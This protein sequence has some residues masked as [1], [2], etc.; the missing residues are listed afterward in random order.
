MKANRTKDCLFLVLL[1]TMMCF[2]A[3]S[4]LA[5][6]AASE[7]NSAAR[8]YLALIENF[9]A[10]AEHHWN[11]KE[12][13][14]DAAGSG[15]TWA[16]G[17]GGVCLVMAVLLTEYPE[18]PEFFP[19]KV[20]RK[21]LIDQVRRAI[22]SVCFAGGS[23]TDPRAVKPSK[24]G[25]ID[26]KNGG[27]HWQG[28]LETEHW[29]L[30]AHLLDAELDNDTRELVRQ[31]ATAEADAAIRSIPSAK[32][33]NTAAD[34][35]AWNAGLLGV[36]SAIYGNDPRAAKWD[37]WAKRWALNMEA[38]ET[39]RASR[40]IIDGRPLGEWLVSTNVFPDLTLE[41]HGF[42]DLPYQPGFAAMAEPIIAYQLCGRKIPEAFHANAVE[43][44]N[45]ILKWLVL[46]DGDLLC[47]QGI[48]WAERDVQHSWAFSILG[49]LEDQAWARAAE[50]RCLKL[51][52]LRQANFGDGSIHAL[53]FGYETDLAVVW[54]F[55]F[56]LHKHFGKAESGLAFDE[57]RGSKIF[58]Y[59]AAAVHRT[60]DLVSSV[61]WFRTRQAIMISP[62][63]L[64]SLAERP[65]FT[66]YDPSSGTGWI[67]FKGEKNG[68]RSR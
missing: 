16:R 27:N 34:D 3:E 44:G 54:T 45:E 39:D 17:N 28:G 46:P 5:Q 2:V 32:R 20:P 38:R 40:R 8:Q 62:N 53:D 13:S 25:G 31:V 48:D 55:S 14:Y 59:V 23:C 6:P 58:P 15:V 52:T 57:P 50:A 19:Q 11:E 9:G 29:A 21:I 33:G 68:A 26:L 42:W 64:E 41:N 47:P 37:D 1:V 7:R 22:R 43:G 36:C 67:D 35:C 65:S 30:A 4:V 56:L 51:L 24:W 61:T 60:A 10:F 63:N 49:T 12:D 18:R 66:R